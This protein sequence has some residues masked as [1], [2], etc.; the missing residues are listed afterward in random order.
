MGI[1]FEPIT[2][3][4]R[5]TKD[6]TAGHVP[7]AAT[8]ETSCRSIV[9]SIPCGDGNN[10]E[11]DS[12]MVT[13]TKMHDHPMETCRDKTHDNFSVESEPH[14][15]DDQSL[16]F[17]KR[18]QNPIRHGRYTWT[19]ELDRYITKQFSFYRLGFRCHS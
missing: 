12:C 18:T 9:P 6:G 19:D 13:D 10:M 1:D 5:T 15:E 14:E 16:S 2:K 3:K 11:R 17:I 8:R 7:D 4:R